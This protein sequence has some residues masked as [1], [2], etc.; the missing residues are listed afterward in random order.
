MQA[1][2]GLEANFLRQMLSEVRANEEASGLGDGGFGGSTFQEMLD[3]ALADN[4]AKA[5]GLGLANMLSKEF[6]KNEG[7]KS[8]APTAANGVTH[9][10]FQ[11]SP[12]SAPAAH[13]A[14]AMP[15]MP[16]SSA[17]MRTLPMSPVGANAAITSAYGGRKDPIEGD[18]R[19]HAGVDLRA[20][21]GT[22]AR[23]ASGGTVVRAGTAGGYGNLVEIDH[24]NGITTRYGH[25]QSI[26]VAVGQH[27][28]AGQEVGEV[29]ATG[30]ATGPH[31]HYEVRQNGKA[32]DPTL[33]LKFSR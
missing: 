16:A 14:L 17:G 15:S 8:S 24:G 6:E 26:N 3:G 22:P 12:M 10:S 31:L 7:A 13:P 11:V 28:D 33:P 25:L 1:A 9:A 29:G 18:A 20:A 23:S 4:M 5:G 27:V 21:A 30:R 2:R 32:I 19:W